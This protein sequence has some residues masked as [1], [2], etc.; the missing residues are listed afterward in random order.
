MDPDPSISIGIILLI[1]LV[2]IINLVI[3]GVSF[4]IKKKQYSKLFL[5]NSIIASI[6]MFYLFGKGID[7][8]QNRLLQT[9]EFK[10]ADSSFSLIRWKETNKFSMDYSLISGSSWSYLEGNCSLVDNDWVFNTDSLEFKIKGNQLIN[11][12]SEMD[13]IEIKRIE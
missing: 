10:I 12:R 2:I 11:F 5:Y 9:W 4:L 13:T 8:Q 1:P 6:L 7:R 3:A